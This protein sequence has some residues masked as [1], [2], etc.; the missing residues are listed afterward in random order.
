MLN[1]ASYLRLTRGSEYFQEQPNSGGGIAL[2]VG[3]LSVMLG[4]NL[5]DNA[6]TDRYTAISF[7]LRDE[8]EGLGVRY[9]FTEE[10]GTRAYWGRDKDRRQRYT[11]MD[12]GFGI[13]PLSL[14]L[15]GPRSGASR[16]D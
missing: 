12:V 14:K 8:L 6:G 3:P 2:P 16:S 7:A 5:V 9:T 11:I 4:E 10:Q 13:E 15:D 1:P